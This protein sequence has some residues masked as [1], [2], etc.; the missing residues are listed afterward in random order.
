MADRM[1]QLRKILLK[2]IAKIW[3]SNYNVPGPIL[4]EN[5]LRNHKYLYN[6]SIN[7]VW[8]I[9]GSYNR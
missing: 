3:H 1:M 9:K 4:H 2:S 7:A 6:S 5:P 8:P